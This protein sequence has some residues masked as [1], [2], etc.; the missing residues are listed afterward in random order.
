MLRRN[1]AALARERQIAAERI[2]AIFAIS[3]LLGADSGVG[4]RYR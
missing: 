1:R 3:V 2:S 4:A